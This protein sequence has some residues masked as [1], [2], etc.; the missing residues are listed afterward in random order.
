MAHHPLGSVRQ[1]PAAPAAWAASECRRD[2]A[3]GAHRPYRHGTWDN[4]TS[5]RAQA[6]SA[7]ANDVQRVRVLQR[8]GH[9]YP[10]RRSGGRAPPSGSSRPACSRCCPSSRSESPGREDGPTPSAQVH[11]SAGRVREGGAL[12]IAAAAFRANAARAA[13]RTSLELLVSRASRRRPRRVGRVH[14]RAHRVDG[15]RRQ[16]T[17]RAGVEEDRPDVPRAWR[18]GRSRWPAALNSM[19]R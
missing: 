7:K 19:L 17:R 14:P 15:P 12:P 13:S 8:L 18:N 6:R 1:A 16:R 11:A 2:S 5:P 9:A 10:P 3:A 4:A